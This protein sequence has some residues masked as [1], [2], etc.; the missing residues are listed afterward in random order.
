MQVLCTST[1][2]NA[3]MHCRVCGK[4]FVMFWERQS[5][6]ERSELMKEIQRALRLHH[7][8][9]KGPEAHPSGSFLMPEFAGATM[10][11]APAAQGQ[12]PSWAL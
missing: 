9:N 10:R 4:G 12:V 6:T 1:N 5:R 11:S 2:G 7:R 3:E 8:I